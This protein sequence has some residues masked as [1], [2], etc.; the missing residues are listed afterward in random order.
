METDFNVLATSHL[1]KLM[2]FRGSYLGAMR[3]LKYQRRGR[4][5]VAELAVILTRGGRRVP[6]WIRNLSISGVNQ[7]YPLHQLSEHQLHKYFDHVCRLLTLHRV[8]PR[9]K[10]LI[11]AAYLTGQVCATAD[12]LCKFAGIARSTA[13]KW[14]SRCVE[15]KLL[16]TF[17]TEHEVYYVQPALMQLVLVGSTEPKHIFRYEFED[18]LAE[19]QGR[20]SMWL[21][22]SK[23]LQRLEKD[24]RTYQV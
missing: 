11:F 2:I 9:T 8:V 5:N 23:L 13:H 15:F 1:A 16:E 14:L 10:N 21:E 6:L 12:S 4:V 18:D 22:R 3:R 24:L 17:Q 7:E 19:L 20:S